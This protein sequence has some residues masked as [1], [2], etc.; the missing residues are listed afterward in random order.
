MRVLD[1]GCGPNKLE[2]ATGIDL[3]PHSDADIIWDLDKIPY[4]IED[5]SFD[6]IYCSHAIE[7]FRTDLNKIMMEFHRILKPDGIVEIRTPHFSHMSAWASYDHIRPFTSNSWDFLCEE[8]TKK[9][10][11]YSKDMWHTEPK[12]KILRKKLVYEN[13]WTGW[14]TKIITAPLEFLANLNP[15]ICE[16]IWCYWVGG[17]SEIY[18]ELKTLKDDVR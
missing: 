10:S 1:V 9:G 8:G 5:N 2:G 12:F 4:P 7:H 14:Y 13:S 16:R 11:R 3:N 17:F 18:I 6:R 15:K